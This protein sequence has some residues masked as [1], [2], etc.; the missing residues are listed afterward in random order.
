MLLQLVVATQQPPP[1]PQARP[2]PA[3]LPAALVR[4]IALGDAE[5]G[6][7]LAMLWL[8][9]FDT[10]PGISLPL[11]TLDYARVEGWLALMLELD[12]RFGYPLLAAARIYGEVPDADR[13]RRMIEFVARAFEAD[14]IARWPWLAHAV[15][16]ARHR[17]GDRA[18]A[19]ALARRL[20]AR[21]PH[22]MPAWARQM[23]IFALADMG[24]IEAAK[25]LLG[26]LLTSG[27]IK[28]EH[29]RRFLAERLAEM[30]H[31]AR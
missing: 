26:A 14:P 19:L 9:A 24:Q 3:P 31:A 15:Y 20:A 12:P 18:L 13:Q 11:A 29:E 5:L 30:E 28:D 1:R 2:L 21:G 8:Q 16:L 10:Q 27:E 7:R 22:D 6:A 17:L 25:V 4:V 23:H